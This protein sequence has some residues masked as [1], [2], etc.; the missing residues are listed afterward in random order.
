MNDTI[1]EKILCVFSFV[2]TM[3]LTIIWTGQNDI[4][5]WTYIQTPIFAACILI[6]IGRIL[7]SGEE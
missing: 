5:H 6:S 1:P 3:V 2:A 7:R 4:F